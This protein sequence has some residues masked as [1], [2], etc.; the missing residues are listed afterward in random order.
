M[1][2]RESVGE[3]LFLVGRIKIGFLEEVVLEL[4]YEGWLRCRL[5]KWGR[6]SE[7]MLSGD[8]VWVRVNV[9]M[10]GEDWD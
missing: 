9:G 10:L 1:E 4:S 6:W 5:V 8:F 2:F 3:S 7:D